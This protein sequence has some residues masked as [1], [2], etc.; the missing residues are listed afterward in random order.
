MG[1]GPWGIVECKD[2]LV[3]GVACCCYF[4]VEV[5]VEGKGVQVF[6]AG[7]CFDACLGVVPDPLMEGVRGGVGVVVLVAVS[8]DGTAY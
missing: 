1:P 3:V 4:V 7:C 8:H 2:A 6:G 5:G